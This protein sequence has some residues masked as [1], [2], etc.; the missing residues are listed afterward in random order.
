MNMDFLKKLWKFYWNDD[1]LISYAFF[2]VVT[3]LLFKFVL[4]PGFLLV[5]GLSDIVAIMTP[6]ME[7]VGFEDYYFYD[8]F[9]TLNYTAGEINAF[10]YSNGLYVGD[11]VFVENT[12]DYEVGDIIVFYSPYY[13][14]KLI[15]RVISVNPLTTKG[16]NNPQSYAF[17]THIS[18]VIG[19]VVFKLPWIGYPRYLMYAVF[20]V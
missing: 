5:T 10:P 13:P 2:L 8:Y 9:Q 15:H 6:S 17:D 11:V 3:Y 18:T 7:H 14:D 20:G 1:S 16:D 19:K 4:F 12:T